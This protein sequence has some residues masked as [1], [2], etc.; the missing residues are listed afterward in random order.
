MSPEELERSGE[1]FKIEFGDSDRKKSFIKY[2]EKHWMAIKAEPKWVSYMRVVGCTEDP[3]V[4]RAIPVPIIGPRQVTLQ[5]LT[6]VTILTESPRNNTNVQNM[7][8]NESGYFEALERMDETARNSISH[9]FNEL[10]RNIRRLKSLTHLTIRGVSIKSGVYQG[11]RDAF[12]CPSPHSRSTIFLSEGL[13]TKHLKE[14]EPDG[15]LIVKNDRLAP[16]SLTARFRNKQDEIPG[17][18]EKVRH[19]D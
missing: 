10:G 11:L 4:E 7:I 14:L 6:S 15:V 2:M 17:Q 1:G 13:Y 16:G 9:H 19:L 18:F 5:N 12:M 8:N 3:F